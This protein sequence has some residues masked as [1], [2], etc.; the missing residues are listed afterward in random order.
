[1]SGPYQVAMDWTSPSRPTNGTQRWLTRQV[2]ADGFSRFRCE[3][4]GVELY[5]DM[6]GMAELRDNNTGEVLYRRLGPTDPAGKQ[7]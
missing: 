1:M 5:V 2:R 6:D 4:A 7:R 3:R